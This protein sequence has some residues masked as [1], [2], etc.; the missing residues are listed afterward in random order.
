MNK[1][2]L[3]GAVLALVSSASL[4]MAQ[5]AGDLYKKHCAMCHG[6]T[7][8]ADSGAGKSMKV[9]PFKAP[10]QMALSDAAIFDTT[11]KGKGKMPGYASKLSDSQI[12]E[13]VAYIRTLQK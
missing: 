12:K 5:S 11:K 10:D 3:A 9:H 1:I 8:A 4:A 2:R 13:V 6:A 7:G